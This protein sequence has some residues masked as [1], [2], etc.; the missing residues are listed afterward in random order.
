MQENLFQNKSVGS[1]VRAFS[2]KRGRVYYAP[3]N[4]KNTASFIKIYSI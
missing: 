1:I 4:V 2:E 3:E